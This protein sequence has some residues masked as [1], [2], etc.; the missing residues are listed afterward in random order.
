MKEYVLGAIIVDEVSAREMIPAIDLVVRTAE[1]C[2][3][4]QA[5][6]AEADWNDFDGFLAG[7]V[8]D[9][10]I[11]EVTYVAQVRGRNG[12]QFPQR[13]KSVY[14]PRNTDLWRSAHKPK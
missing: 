4:G 5:R 7:L 12:D 13:A 8:E 6:L 1:R 9:G 2:I 14:F 10:E 3:A 11:R